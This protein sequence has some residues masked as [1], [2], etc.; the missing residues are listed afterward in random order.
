[1]GR[2]SEEEEAHDPA[3]RAA[4]RSACLF[5]FAEDFVFGRGGVTWKREN[6]K[7]TRED[8]RKV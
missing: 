7:R 2:T 1:M 6:K 5:F 3:E 8:G 4:R